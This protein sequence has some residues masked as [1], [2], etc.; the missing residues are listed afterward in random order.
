[1]RDKILDT[2]RY[3]SLERTLLD[4]TPLAIGDLRDPRLGAGRGAS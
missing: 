2:A 1:M 3:P 4:H